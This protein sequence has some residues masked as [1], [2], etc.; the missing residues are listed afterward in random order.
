MIGRREAIAM[1]RTL[2]PGERWAAFDEVRAETR[3]TSDGLFWIVRLLP[4]RPE[5]IV[6]D[7]RT[8]TAQ[9]VRMTGD[10]W[11]QSTD[12][13]AMLLAAVDRADPRLIWRFIAV[14]GR[15]VWD[16]LPWEGL[17][18]AMATT[19]RWLDGQA[20]DGDLN[21][22][23]FD[24]TAGGAS[25]VEGWPTA[26]ELLEDYEFAKMLPPEELCD[27]MRRVL[28]NPFLAEKARI[29]PEGA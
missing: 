4:D 9:W 22:A 2:T 12:P 18:T 24:A 15:R 26:Y 10:E 17:R 13:R 23:W 1:A 21:G 29:G 20:G 16:Q 14:L 27:M 5:S 25:L 3:V 11:E 8:A 28:G 7:C 19:E 6:V